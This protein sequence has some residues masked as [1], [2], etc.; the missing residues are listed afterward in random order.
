VLVCLEFNK[1]PTDLESYHLE[2]IQAEKKVSA[3]KSKI[4][5]EAPI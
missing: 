5:H 1:Y 2:A 4:E 3:L